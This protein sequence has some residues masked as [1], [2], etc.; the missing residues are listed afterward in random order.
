MTTADLQTLET[1]WVNPAEADISSGRRDWLGSDDE[2]VSRPDMFR[3]VKN[4][5][6][7]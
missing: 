3:R 4:L 5:V 2:E 1:K 7:G 6:I